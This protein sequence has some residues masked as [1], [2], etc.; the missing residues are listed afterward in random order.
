MFFNTCLQTMKLAFILAFLL[1]ATS[2]LAWD[3]CTSD[4]PVE[5]WGVRVKTENVDGGV[6]VAVIVS[7][8]TEVKIPSTAE[9]IITANIGV[10]SLPDIVLTL[11]NNI[12]VGEFE[13]E[14]SQVIETLDNV[15]HVTLKVVVKDND[16]V[17][18]CIKN[19]RVDFP[20]D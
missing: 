18:S 1:L 20:K 4:G 15:T 10:I 19:L 11:D 12:D 14:R 9:V 2:T 3:V 13:F 17:V 6:A 16:E 5:I 8:N 7:G